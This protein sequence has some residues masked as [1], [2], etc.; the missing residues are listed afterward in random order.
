MV[1]ERF[2]LALVMLA[3]VA[4]ATVA[5]TQS[6]ADSI[7]SDGASPDQLELNDETHND[8]IVG[9][10]GIFGPFRNEKVKGHRIYRHLVL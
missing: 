10:T 2:L 8:S 7:E 3:T 6:I 4:V 5:C 1:K 9:G